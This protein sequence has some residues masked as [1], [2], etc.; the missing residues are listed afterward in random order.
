MRRHG[1]AETVRQRGRP[2]R[3]LRGCQW[4]RRRVPTSAGGQK[5]GVWVDRTWRTA[6]TL[7]IRTT[8]WPV[9]A[10]SRACWR[11]TRG[12]LGRLVRL[13]G[14]HC[15]RIPTT[16]GPHTRGFIKLSHLQVPP[17]RRRRQDSTLRHA[18][19]GGQRE[20]CLSERQ[21]SLP[22]APVEL[23]TTSGSRGCTTW[24]VCACFRW[25]QGCGQMCR[26][27]CRAPSPSRWRRLGSGGQWHV[28]AEG[29]GHSTFPRRCIFFTVLSS[30]ALLDV[31]KWPWCLVCLPLK[32]CLRC[33]LSAT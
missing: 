14:P 19:R 9:Q 17:L 31:L 21:A 15:S 13:G 11:Q 12:S 25:V 33:I 1:R 5:M 16:T 30:A 32:R 26:F 3:R 28:S 29:E 8:V 22:P 10:R 24:K 20:M 6:T 4:R 18:R 2:T 7:A 23:W 27:V